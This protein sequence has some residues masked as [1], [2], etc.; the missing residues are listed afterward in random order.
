MYTEILQGKCPACS[1]IYTPVATSSAFLEHLPGHKLLV[2]Y[3]LCPK[4]KTAH[5]SGSSKTRTRIQ[6]ACFCNVKLSSESLKAWTITSSVAY[7]AHGGDFYSAWFYG[8][9]I[10]KPLLEAMDRGFINDVV[11]FPGSPVSC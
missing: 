3:A 7:E 5:A 10:P 6:N 9:S 8:I 1:N 11:F 4:C 2:V